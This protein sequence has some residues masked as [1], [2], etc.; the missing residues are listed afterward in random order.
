MDCSP[1]GSPV[2][3]ISQTRILERVAI[4]SSRGSSQPGSNPPCLAS[5]ALAGRFFTILPPGKP[6]F[7]NK[8]VDSRWCSIQDRTNT[9]EHTLAGIFWAGFLCIS[10]LRQEW[11]SSTKDK[12]SQY[13]IF[14]HTSLLFNGQQV[15]RQHFFLLSALGGNRRYGRT[16]RCLNKNGMKDRHCLRH[17]NS[18]LYARFLNSTCGQGAFPHS[19]RF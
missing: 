19:L 18:L 13:M 6:L 16:S 12:M 15:P 4:S 14:F 2:H 1:P 9:K 5:P 11:L 10:Q 7:V 3:G 17:R 8:L